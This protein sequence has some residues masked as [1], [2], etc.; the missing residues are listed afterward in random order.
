MSFVSLL[1]GPSAVGKS[2]LARRLVQ[3][4]SNHVVVRS[5][6]TRGQRP[7]E[8]ELEYYFSSRGEFLEAVLQGYFLE[9]V[10]EKGALYGTP[11]TPYYEYLESGMYPVKAI[12]A[13]G[14]RS[15]K[16]EF[17]DNCISIFIS[18]PSL[19]ELKRRM[20]NRDGALNKLRLDSYAEDM[21]VADQCDYVVV[22]SDFDTCFKEIQAI[23]ARE[24]AKRSIN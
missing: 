9:H 15:F 22:N 4:N 5:W 14:V 1:V 10:E 7:G 16:E 11:L 23:I 12:E 20:N 13:R 8:D 2:S 18:P 24:S 21:G 17:G 3:V 19:E 6:T